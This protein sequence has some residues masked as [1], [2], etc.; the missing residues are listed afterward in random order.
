[1]PDVPG[2]S[3]A[4]LEARA[5]ALARLVRQAWRVVAQ[6]ISRR[7]AAATVVT[8]AQVDTVPTEWAIEVEDRVLG[9]I[10]NTYLDAAGDVVTA[11]G[12]SDDVLI[13]DDLVEAFLHQAR[14]RL[15]GVGDDVW[16]VAREQ[17]VL[18]HR[19]GESPG[20][21]A[22]RI[23]NVTG[24][25]D[26]R[27][28][29]IARTEVHA[30]YEAGA[31]EQALFVDPTATKTWLATNDSRTRETHRVANGQR[32]P[33]NQSFEVGDSALR[34]PGDPLGEPGE[35][36]G[37]RCSVAYDFDIITPVNSNPGELAL[38][39]AGKWNPASHPRGNDG[40]FI[41][42]GAVSTLLSKQKLLIGDV[43][44]AV[45]E[46]D[47][48]SWSKLTDAQKEYVAASV[49]KLPTGSVIKKNATAKLTKLQDFDVK[50]DIPIGQLDPAVVSSKTSVSAHKGAMPGAP[51]KVTTTLIWG[52][53]EPGTIILEAEHGI[54][55]VIWNG[56]K[57]EWHSR[58]EQ[59]VFVKQFEMTKKDAYAQL[60]NDSGWVVPGAQPSVADFQADVKTMWQS[61]WDKGLI[62]TDEF[63]TQFGEKPV[64]SDTTLAPPSP[65]APTAA[66]TLE[67]V[68]HLS[69]MQDFADLKKIS[70]QKGSNP[71]GIFEEPS[72]QRWYVKKAKSPKH[73]ANEV[74][75]S[76]LYNL[77]GVATPQVRKGTGA[78][79]INGGLQTGTELVP[80]A[81]SDLSTKLKDPT[82]RKKL[83]GGF[84][85]DAWLG[86]W[87][88][89]GLTLDNVVTGED[90]DPH[91]ID[92]GG[93]MLFRAMGAPK[94]DAFGDQVTELETL[95]DS[96]KN[97]Q[98]A[99]IFGDM[100]SEE[101][102]ESAQR[103]ATIT[104]EQIDQ[105]IHDSGLPTSVA[106]TLKNRRN[107]IAQ[108][109][110][111]L[112]EPASTTSPVKKAAK[113]AVKKAANV[114][115]PELTPTQE[116]LLDLQNYGSLLPSQ[117]VTLVN[118]M[119]QAD[120]DGLTESQQ[121]SL[122]L[123]VDTALDNGTPGANDAFTRV[124]AFQS[125][126]KTQAAQ[127]PTPVSHLAEDVIT[128]WPGI[129]QNVMAGK[130]ETGDV[131]ALSTNGQYQ[132]VKYSDGASVNVVDAQSGKILTSYSVYTDHLG[133]VAQDYPGTWVVP[134]PKAKLSPAMAIPVTSTSPVTTEAMIGG[135]SPSALWSASQSN[136]AGFIVASGFDANDKQYQLIVVKN[137]DGS[138]R[139]RVFS[140]VNGP[141][142]NL[143]NIWSQESLQDYLTTAGA[144]IDWNVAP[145]AL[146]PE[147]PSAT[148]TIGLLSPKAIFNIGIT[149]GQMGEII[150]VGQSPGGSHRLIVSQGV[151]GKIMIL[152]V[153]DPANPGTWY[154]SG[155]YSSFEDY[156]A[157]WGKSIVWGPPP[158][159]PTVSVESDATDT[160]S[161]MEIDSEETWLDVAEQYS[162]VAD[163]TVVAVAGNGNYR[164]VA[165]PGSSY[166]V[167][168]F[169]GDTGQW[170]D[171]QSFT[172]QELD[173]DELTFSDVMH[174][175]AA[176]WSTSG[177][178][179]EEF[180]PPPGTVTPTS[181]E[182]FQ[183]G[184]SL[185]LKE[186]QAYVVATD[187]PAGTV[188]GQTVDGQQRIVATGS[189]TGPKY[190]RQ[191]LA[192][193]GTWTDIIALQ[194]IGVIQ[195]LKN[196]GESW[197][198]PQS[199]LNPVLAQASVPDAP[200]P[201]TAPV[202]PQTG[203][204]SGIHVATKKYFKKHFGA[205]KVGYW[206]KPEKIW[207]QIKQIQ[208]LFPST[209][210]SGQS[211]YT[212]LQI[213]KSLDDLTKTKDPN[214]FETKMVKWAAT[215]KGQAYTGGS[216][217]MT[218]TPSA[219]PTSAE[220]TGLGVW[221]AITW[222]PEYGS[223]S[224]STATSP[225]V[226]P[227]GKLD[228]GTGDISHLPDAQ[229]QTL[230]SK[231]KNQPAMY[232]SSSDPDVFN[233]AKTI[234]DEEGISLL[235]ML[236]VIDAVGAKKVNKPDEHLFEKKIKTWLGT[237]Q[238]AAVASGKPIPLPESPKYSPSVDPKKI[239]SF[240]ASSKLSY[241]VIHDAKA[242][243]LTKA[244]KAASPAGNWTATQQSGLRTYTGGTYYSINAFYRG[245]INSISP[246][247]EKAA[248][249]AQLAMR[250]STEPMLLHRGV[251]WDGVGGAKSHAD[252]EKM[253]GQTWQAGGFFSTSVGGS[254]A[255]GGP[256]MLEIEAPPGTPM[257]YVE[258]PPDTSATY[259]KVTQHP[260]EREMLLAAGLN[261]KIIS[262]KKAGSKTVVRMR[263]VPPSVEVTA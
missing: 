172:A 232:L 166:A 168:A 138:S 126:A 73:A 136:P 192:T 256:V 225:S 55:R 187:H 164:L 157:D 182:T 198:V 114:A 247:N 12:V 183:T 54:D 95:R 259:K 152:Q 40:K 216:S 2:R 159:V 231:F 45:A 92:V 137:L 104:D 241:G 24:V 263:V 79:D 184:Q 59:G 208:A 133:F 62:T 25:S 117:S 260:G 124:S 203:D 149:G 119:N 77:A 82:Y 58:D 140:N 33:I 81:K 120:W 15:R 42:K 31:Y 21:L 98:S 123:K 27:S 39:A 100:T 229:Q 47:A 23:R 48:G 32:V 97:P 49:M 181:T 171:V 252:I 60:K 110:P 248:K 11:I 99:Q 84:A 103:V 236:R 169:N 226:S 196:S 222:K 93:A 153:E 50:K 72:G 161:G 207:D 86:N 223:G 14:N 108:L 10:E 188:I 156:D 246:T 112:A 118:G 22:T 227:A 179:V 64:G 251:G 89:A 135:I 217:P 261:F 66:L 43:T 71:G 105:V 132:L 29:M 94:G 38:V 186:L 258:A 150:A 177:I 122:A 204:T 219:A 218:S 113:K 20:Q 170:T 190:V 28:L 67:S 107:Y 69:E 52:K 121:T 194:N 173:D 3:E 125:A 214:P 130:Y 148:P 237:P 228:M 233:A 210:N 212:P 91:R 145:S 139:L 141:W 253:S 245:K 151:S 244:A 6:L 155:Y 167:Q 235:Q 36:I 180:G 56:K 243:A 175:F 197:L 160:E 143:V 109:Y 37:C 80:G 200:T 128:S 257:A 211:D 158:S 201:A 262:V 111:S 189:D 41:K 9:F 234:A 61:Q 78:P 17:L 131:V 240:E 26:A 239:M 18:G 63:E 202:T 46:L 44:K 51:A 8:A 13:G 101:I 57:Y 74:A 19:E 206:S 242:Q 76:A 87:D 75:A 85:V 162:N 220:L 115:D 255:F 163:F 16:A 68:E 129:A 250:P 127:A 230:Y 254:A 215:A 65:V 90:G 174:S 88:V 102:E 1:M 116:L 106:Q 205:A 154:A 7:V 176:E 134:P 213:L 34:F 4:E 147:V 96:N 249:N 191:Q 224:A 83:Q 53:Y 193:D 185:T 195:K 30:A 199:K 165:E 142:G 221:N 5:Y 146:L 178:S 70:G 209:T 238:G 35:T 144:G